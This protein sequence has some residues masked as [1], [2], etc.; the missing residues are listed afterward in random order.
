MVVR[1]INF[2][3]HIN[4]V[5]TNH[6]TNQQLTEQQRATVPN[7]NVWL[8]RSR[9]GRCPRMKMKLTDW[10]LLLFWENVAVCPVYVHP[11]HRNANKQHIR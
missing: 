9:A 3:T 4:S 5:L 6:P 10:L 8:M 2:A 11:R 7:P 1:F